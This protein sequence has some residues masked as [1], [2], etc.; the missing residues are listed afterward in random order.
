MRGL[1]LD[2]SVGLLTLRLDLIH[3]SLTVLALSVVTLAVAEK[4]KAGPVDEILFGA[5]NDSGA[6]DD[7]YRGAAA[8]GLEVG[9]GSLVAAPVPIVNPT[10]GFGGALAGLFSFEA[11]AQP[12]A[13]RSTLGLVTGYT[14][15]DSWLIAGG[16][17][18]F[19]D[20]DRY[21]LSLIAGFGNLNLEFFGIGD[22][23]ILA[24]NPIEYTARGGFVGA[25]AQVRVEDGLF[26]GVKARYLDASIKTQLPIPLLPSIE[27]PFTLSG[28]GPQLEYDDREGTWWP[29]GGA[30]ARFELL[31]YDD[32]LG[33]DRSFRTSDADLSY[34]HQLADE[35]VLAG[36][37]RLA[38]ASDSAPFFMKPFVSLRGF[39]AGRFLDDWV[40]EVQGEIRWTLGWRVGVVGFAGLGTTAPRF[41]SLGGDQ[42]TVGVGAGLRYRLSEVDGLNLGFDY[43]RGDG[44]SSFYFRLGEAF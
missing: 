5:M 37:A 40:A 29:T 22:V 28:F 14:D 12:E 41:S 2:C 36:N 10:L 24:S 26:V 9:G 3:R 16:G 33:S 21:R 42:T 27:V 13:P 4:P 17:Q 39:P 38:T 35:L 30:R 34:Y 25:T 23:P 1:P 18:T 31:W 15:T 43:A 19:L 7:I 44:E 20:G 32:K 6:V 11:S 8:E